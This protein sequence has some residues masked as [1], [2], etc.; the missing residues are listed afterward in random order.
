MI[1]TGDAHADMA[2][3]IHQSGI[4][5]HARRHGQFGFEFDKFRHEKSPLSGANVFVQYLAIMYIEPQPSRNS[6]LNND[7]RES[8]RRRLRRTTRSKR[9]LKING[10]NNSAEGIRWDLSDLYAAHDD[11]RIETT[12]ND[13]RARAERVCR[14]FPRLSMQVRKRSRPRPSSGTQGIGKHL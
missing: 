14:S 2:A 8:N 7:Y 13:C 5:Q 4:K 12:L 10:M 9:S 3:V 1:R 6:T 11:P